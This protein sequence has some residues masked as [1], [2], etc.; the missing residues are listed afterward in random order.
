MRFAV[1]LALAALFIPSASGLTPGPARI[2][3]T[4]TRI[5]SENNYDTYALYNRPAFPDR[6]GTAFVFC[7]PALRGYTDCREILRLGRGQIVARGVVPSA[8]AFRVLAVL[9]GTGYYANAGGELIVQPLGG[10]QL[11]LVTLQAF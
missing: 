5:H 6:L 1:A 9:G 4:A 7:T 10:A 11:I 8:S 3:L 2:R